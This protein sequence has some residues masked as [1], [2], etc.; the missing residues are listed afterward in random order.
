MRQRLIFTTLAILLLAALF[1]SP[2]NAQRGMRRGM[3]FG[4][5]SASGN[6]GRIHRA[7]GFFPEGAFW[8]YY[9]SDYE[10]SSEGPII[11]APPPTVIVQGAQANAQSSV[12][13]PAAA[14]VLELDG[15]HWV[16][17]TNSGESEIGGASPQAE[18]V[19][20]STIPQSATTVLTA[21]RTETPEA[22]SEIPAAVL[23]YRDGHKEEIRKYIVVGAAIYTTADYWTSGSWTRKIQIAE[24]DVPATLKLNREQGAKFSL[25]SAPNE[26]MVR[27]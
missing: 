15:D 13:K 18:P 26:I 24:L 16:R 19:A 3:P 14:L 22:A 25:P 9:Y 7:G 6:F 10:S 8:P 20:S 23:V 4:A 27:P 12:Q 5:R 21:R 1:A 17:V 11:E 2:A